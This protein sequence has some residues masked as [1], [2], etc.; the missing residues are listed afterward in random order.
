MIS[1]QL[2]IFVKFFSS[3]SLLSLP[4]FRLPGKDTM[5]VLLCCAQEQEDDHHRTIHYNRSNLLL[6]DQI[7]GK[8]TERERKTE[9]KRSVSFSRYFLYIKNSRMEITCIIIRNQIMHSSVLSC[10]SRTPFFSS[11][12][13]MLL[14]K[15]TFVRISKEIENKNY[16]AII[17]QIYSLQKIYLV[18]QVHEFFKIKIEKKLSQIISISFNL[19][20]NFFFYINQKVKMMF[21]LFS[22]SFIISIKKYFHQL[23]S[24]SHQLSLI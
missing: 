20:I 13:L 4:F 17:K 18:D 19:E 23:E 24:I 2:V 21:I 5:N 7:L 15:S 10:W 22:I 11:T 12:I 3:S 14:N 6:L 1:S 16:E 9:R 8:E